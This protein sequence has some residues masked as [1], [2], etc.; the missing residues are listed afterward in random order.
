MT[1]TNESDFSSA[2][3]LDISYEMVWLFEIKFFLMMKHGFT[4]VAMSAAKV[5]GYG[6]LN[7]L[8]VSRKKLYSA[9]NPHSFQEKT[10]HSL[11]IEMCCAVSQQRVV[12]PI[13][14]TETVP[15]QHYQKIIEQSI[16]LL[17]EDE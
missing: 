6:A 14:F 4:S 13:F 9:E 3:G 7:T 12:A 2:S 17:E 16:A 8:T 11:K 10:L 1:M 5:A 15:A